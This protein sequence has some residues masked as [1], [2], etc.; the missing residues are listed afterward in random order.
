MS[1]AGSFR[2]TNQLTNSMKK[3]PSW[4]A[5]SHSPSQEIPHLLWNPKIR[6]RVHKNPSAIPIMSQINPV[7]TFP[8]IYSSIIFTYLTMIKHAL[9]IIKLYIKI[10]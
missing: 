6:Y 5:T 2:T 7:H 10:R 8:N 9:G 1:L 4:E 3:S